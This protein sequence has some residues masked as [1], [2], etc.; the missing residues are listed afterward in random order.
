MISMRPRHMPLGSLR[1][2]LPMPEPQALMVGRNTGVAGR[3][4]RLE[5]E[6]APLEAKIASYFVS[7]VIIPRHESSSLP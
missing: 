2:G 3:Q 7:G 5:P 6:Q 4:K 1:H